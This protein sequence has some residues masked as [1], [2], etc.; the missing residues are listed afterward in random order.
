MPVQ[1]GTAAT[2]AP[3]IETPTMRVRPLAVA[4]AY[5]FTP[6]RF[7]DRRGYFVSPFQED[8]FHLAVGR[9][10]LPVAQTNISRS[11][12]GVV[13]GI[14]F[15]ATPPGQAKYVSCIGGRSRDFVVDLRIGSPT[16]GQWDM[17]ILDQEDCRAVY[18]PVGVG[19]AFAAEEPDT[20]MS[21]LV[22]SAYVPEN[23]LAVDVR[24][25]VLGLPLPPGA[26]DRLSE[27]DTVA[28]TLAEARAAGLLPTYEEAIRRERAQAG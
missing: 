2:G 27:R 15:T 4:G 3:V 21:Y 11:D 5:A 12:L 19:H 6:R 8:A 16:F 26:E 20:V 1:H 13:R 23:E 17:V 25:P 7:A 10:T 28:P 9:R 14:H 24:D 18:L 22:S